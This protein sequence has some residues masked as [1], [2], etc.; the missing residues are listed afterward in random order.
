VAYL[1]PLIIYL[2]S[3]PPMDFDIAKDGPYALI[4]LPARELAEQVEKDF[5]EL[6]VNLRIRC[7]TMVGGR[8]EEE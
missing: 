7:M 5:K 8:R 1:I 4:L 2:K 3:L 6:T